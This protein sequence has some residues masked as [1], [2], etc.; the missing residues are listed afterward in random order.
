VNPGIIK[1]IFWIL[2]DRPYGR[3]KK[4]EVNQVIGGKIDHQGNWETKAES[5]LFQQYGLRIR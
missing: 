5:F 1:L 3:D 2:I 4:G